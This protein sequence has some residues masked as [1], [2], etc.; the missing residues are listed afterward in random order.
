[1]RQKFTE[2]PVLQHF[3]LTKLV[4]VLTNASDFAIAAILLQPLDTDVPTEKH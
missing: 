2:A 1:L 3:D 4:I